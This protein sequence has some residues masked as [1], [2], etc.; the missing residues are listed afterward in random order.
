VASRA[1]EI[2]NAIKAFVT[3]RN[4]IL[5]HLVD[6]NI[7]I[8]CYGDVFRREFLRIFRFKKAT[9]LKTIAR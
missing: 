4:I 2:V 5:L 7:H 1:A 9:W 6:E 3:V 8:T